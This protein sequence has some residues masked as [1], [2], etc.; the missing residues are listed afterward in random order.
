MASKTV[1]RP[2]GLLRC[3]PAAVI[4]QSNISLVLVLQHSNGN[5]TLTQTIV[6]L[7]QWL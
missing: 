5:L 6:N 7:R 4:G 3:S 2:V 1:I